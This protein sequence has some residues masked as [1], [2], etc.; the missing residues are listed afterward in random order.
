MMIV[1]ARLHLLDEVVPYLYW[2]YKRRDRKKE[3]QIIEQA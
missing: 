3:T 1:D 2:A